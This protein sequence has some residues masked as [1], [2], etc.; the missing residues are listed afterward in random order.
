MCAVDATD[1]SSATSS[2]PGGS[3]GDGGFL[4]RGVVALLIG[5][6]AS[7]AVAGETAR[8]LALFDTIPAL[9]TRTAEIS[10]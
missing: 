5:G 6:L 10:E 9:S 2:P 3:S 7:F 1:F 4:W 8:W